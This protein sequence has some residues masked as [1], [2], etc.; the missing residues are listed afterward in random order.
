[1]S[2]LGGS[3]TEPVKGSKRN[4]LLLRNLK[5][6]HGFVWSQWELIVGRKLKC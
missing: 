4:M 6:E 2:N 5:A 3:P 1:M